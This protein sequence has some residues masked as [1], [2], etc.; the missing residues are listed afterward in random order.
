[1]YKY[2]NSTSNGSSF[3]LDWSKG[4]KTDLKSSMKLYSGKKEKSDKEF[5]SNRCSLKQTK[6][7]HESSVYYR[8]LILVKIR[9]V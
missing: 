1:M 5:D 9:H 8:R 2:S 7:R 6:K 3:D 4:S